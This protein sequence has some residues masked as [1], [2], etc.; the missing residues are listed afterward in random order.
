MIRKAEI[1]KAIEEE[2][3]LLKKAVAEEDAIQRTRHKAKL[4][5]LHWVI[6]ESLHY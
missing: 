5:V 6:E 1:L 4:I 2:K 3:K